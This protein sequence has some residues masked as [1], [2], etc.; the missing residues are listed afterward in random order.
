MF[1]AKPVLANFVG[2]FAHYDADVRK[3]TTELAI[4]LY[5]W[6]GQTVK[7]CVSS[8]RPAQV[9][10]GKSL[11]TLLDEGFKCR[12]RESTIWQAGANTLIA[13]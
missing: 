12:L 8:L 11:F 13:F 6:Y 1:P 3:E 10:R 4:E 2:W 5:K 9:Q 7:K